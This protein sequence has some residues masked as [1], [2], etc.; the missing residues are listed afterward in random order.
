MID[1]VES[2]HLFGNTTLILAI[3]YEFTDLIKN[4]YNQLQI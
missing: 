1:N 4:N 2:Y 3:R